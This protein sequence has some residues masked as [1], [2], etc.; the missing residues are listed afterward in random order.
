M[1]QD[2]TDLTSNA[3]GQSHNLP[4]LAGS[5]LGDTPHTVEE[6]I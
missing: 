3:P 4:V 2:E 5:F 1:Q 6:Q